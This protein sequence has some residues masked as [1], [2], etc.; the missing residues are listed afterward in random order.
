MTW[1]TIQAACDRKEEKFSRGIECV[2]VG[3]VGA[4][5]V[6]MKYPPCLGV[7]DELLYRC[8]VS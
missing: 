3:P 4:T 2:A 6:G 7:A 8:V 5:V 1:K